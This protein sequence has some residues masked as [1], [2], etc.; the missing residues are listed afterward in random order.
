MEREKYMFL[1]Q[2]SI[3]LT[4][5]SEAWIINTIS[6][7][8]KQVVEMKFLGSMLGVYKDKIR[9]EEELNTQHHIIR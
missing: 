4:Y 9:N 1:E 5:G 3:A 8:K 2:Y 7:A 6:K